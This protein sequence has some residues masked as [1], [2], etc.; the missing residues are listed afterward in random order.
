M[1]KQIVG[2]LRL[3]HRSTLDWL[4]NTFGFALSQVT[5]PEGDD[6]QHAQLTYGTSVLMASQG[7]RVEQD[8]GK[9]STYLTVATDQEVDQGYARAIAA[10]ADSILEPENQPYGGRNA[11]V[12]DP[13]GNVWSIGSYQP[14]PG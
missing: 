12:S 13:E 1:S 10:G 11:T 3:E 8:T 5:P 4:A 6:L 9:A 2:I 7:G 14:T